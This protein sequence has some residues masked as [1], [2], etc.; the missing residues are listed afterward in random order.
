MTL[1]VIALITARGGSKAVPRKNVAPIGGKPLI[2]WTIEAAL[3]SKSVKRVVVSTDDEEIAQISR[4]WGAE[5]PF[6]RPAALA[7]DDSPH[8][9]VVM[10]AHEWLEAREPKGFDQLLLLQPTSPLRNAEDIDNAVELSRK[11]NAE[12]VVSV[13]EAT[14]HPFLTK[15]VTE[16]GRIEDFIPPPPGY[17]ARQKLPTV[18]AVNGALYLI[19]RDLLAE[20]KSFY[21]DRTYAYV[22]PV[23]RSLDIDTAWDLHLG[24]LILSDRARQG[25]QER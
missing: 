14:S 22:M 24:N 15:R 2:A 21:T 18:Y 9:P 19:R 3:E 6:M 20:Q 11:K 16:D 23:E 1:S 12:S 25:K 17:L 5:V 10:H 8:M 4:Q 13:S 7:Q